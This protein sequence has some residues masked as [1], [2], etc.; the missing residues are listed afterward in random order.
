MA[1][2]AAPAI[3]LPIRLP[4]Y[5]PGKGRKDGLILESL[6]PAWETQTKPLAPGYGLAQPGLCDNP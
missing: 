1:L 2:I 6:P 5:G 4:S 3:L